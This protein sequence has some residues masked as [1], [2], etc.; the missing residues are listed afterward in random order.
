MTGLAATQRIF[1]AHLAGDDATMPDI[2]ND[3][4]AS[5][6]RRMDIYR[7]AYRMTLRGALRTNHR[8]CA[9]WLGDDRFDA[10][11]DTY[12]AANPS[13]FRNLRD[14]GGGFATFLGGLFPDDLDIAELAAL[15]WAVDATFDG[16]DA[17]SLTAAAIG[18]LSPEDWI[19]RALALHPAASLVEATHNLAPVWQALE[20]NEAPPAMV[21]LDRRASLLVWRKDGRPHFRTLDADEDQALRLAA[22][23]TCFADICEHLG[24]R[25][26]ETAAT[27]RA[28]A[29]LRRWLD[30]AVLCWATR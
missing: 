16:P 27:E 25:L 8:R 4:T 6:A 5:A 20:Q 15:D 24:N 18:A 13:P 1:L 10:A 3:R 29:L 19:A 9:A 21:A 12:I 22:S 23:G 17:S 26:G 11:A 7:N 14:Y 28:G 30:D 2:V